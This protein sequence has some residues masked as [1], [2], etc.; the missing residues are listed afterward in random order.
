MYEYIHVLQGHEEAH[1]CRKIIFQNFW[2][3][4]LF[5]SAEILES[6]R[7]DVSETGSV[8]VLR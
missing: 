7:H 3:F 1:F 6:R 5:P 2:V 4:G 8:S